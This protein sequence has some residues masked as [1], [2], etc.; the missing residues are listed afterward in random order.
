M[1]NMSLFE[2]FLVLLVFLYQWPLLDIHFASVNVVFT[3]LQNCLYC[4]MGIQPLG[5]SLYIFLFCMHTSLISA[6][7][8]FLS[9]LFLFEWDLVLEKIIYLFNIHLVTHIDP[10][11]LLS[12]HTEIVQLSFKKTLLYLSLFVFPFSDS[13]SPGIDRSWPNKLLEA[14]VI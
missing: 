11:S 14:N 10:L 1:F 12:L 9:F 7:T 2:W 5:I 6:L 8:Q 3:N 4:S 13:V